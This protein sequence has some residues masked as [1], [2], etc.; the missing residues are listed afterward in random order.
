MSSGLS[1]SP[2]SCRGGRSFS[3]PGQMAGALG[4]LKHKVI[5]FTGLLTPA[6]TRLGP[7]SSEHRCSIPPTLSARS[8]HL[9][10]HTFLSHGW[11]SLMRPASSHLTIASSSLV[12][13]TVPNSPVGFPK[14]PN[15][16]TRSPGFRF[17]S[18]AGGSAR[19][20]FLARSQS[21]A[22][23]GY[24]SGG[25]GAFR[26]LDIGLSVIWVIIHCFFPRGQSSALRRDRSSFPI[27]SA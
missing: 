18:F 26:S 20:G 21:E 9:F 19:R 10:G 1:S 25:C 24:D 12:C 3:R 17:W 16:S 27:N 11:W 14:L 4:V 6:P 22:A 13:S 7:T 5:E 2:N 23:P 8:M 15:P